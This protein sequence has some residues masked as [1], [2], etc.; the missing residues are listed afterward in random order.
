MGLIS[1]WIGQ[2]C[3]PKK[4]LPPLPSA[5]VVLDSNLIYE[6]LNE[7][8]VVSTELTAKDLSRKDLIAWM[9]R[10]SV[11]VSQKKEAIV[12]G[13][14]RKYPEAWF[15]TQVINRGNESKQL[16]VYEYN[17]L[18]CDGFEVFTTKNGKITQWGSL[19]RSTPFSNYPFLFSRMQSP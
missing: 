5:V 18:R 11:K 13:P 9:S 8:V 16:I 15:C 3:T 7:R 1:L 17:R 12:L 6:S 2:G 14:F 4:A 10:N 19:D